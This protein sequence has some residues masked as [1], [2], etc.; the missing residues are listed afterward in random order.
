MDGKPGMGI[1]PL[2]SRKNIS[3]LTDGQPPS[4]YKLL[5]ISKQ[6]WQDINGMFHTGIHGTNN[7]CF[8]KHCPSPDLHFLLQFFDGHVWLYCQG[9]NLTTEKFHRDVPCHGNTPKLSTRSL[10]L[11]HSLRGND[12]TIFLSHTH[13]KQ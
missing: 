9:V 12:N 13:I 5:L 3:T 10:V 11:N 4:T 8:W 1:I 7:R 6:T 2:F